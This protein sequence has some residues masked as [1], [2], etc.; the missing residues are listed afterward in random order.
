VKWLITI[1][2]VLLLVLQY[3]LW[4]GDSSVQ[5]YAALRKEAN[6][7]H[8][9]LLQLRSRNQALEAEVADL[10]SGLDAIEE[11]A[12]NELGMIDEDETF[13]QFVKKRGA[14]GSVEEDPELDDE[15]DELGATLPDADGSAIGRPESPDDCGGYLGCYSRSRA[16]H[17]NDILC[18]KTISCFAW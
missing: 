3:R 13:Y 17:S 9:E 1:L 11:R 16:R 7:T 14:D 4:F 10:K 12:R 6:Q 5:A 2:V 8:Q 18:A 15:T